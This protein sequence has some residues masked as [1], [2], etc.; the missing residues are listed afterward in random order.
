[1]C[2]DSK[3]W[4]NN[5]EMR[6]ALIKCVCLQNIV[7]INIFA[8][9]RKFY[10]VFLHWAESKS[11]VK[12]Y[13][14]NEEYVGLVCFQCGW[15]TVDVMCV[16]IYRKW[17]TPNACSLN[18]WHSK[19][20]CSIFLVRTLSKNWRKIHKLFKF[21]APNA[22]YIIVRILIQICSRMRLY[23]KWKNHSTNDVHTTFMIDACKL[24]YAV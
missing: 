6:V 13:G 22:Q 16:D 11:N 20:N 3:N 2:E 9:I 1:M 23:E 15:I 17:A 21:N 12:R 19:S 8:S 10:F 4:I 14:K 7:E 5:N 24:L 18:L